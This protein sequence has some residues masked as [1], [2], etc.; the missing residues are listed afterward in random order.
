MGKVFFLFCTRQASTMGYW[1]FLRASRAS[2]FKF[3][4]EASNWASGH[5]FISP[6]LKRRENINNVPN[7]SWLGKNGD[8]Q[9]STPQFA[10]MG[11]MQNHII[12]LSRG[13]KLRHF[14]LIYNSR[15]MFWTSLKLSCCKTAQSVFIRSITYSS[16]YRSWESHSSCRSSFSPPIL[17][18][19]IANF[20]SFSYF[21]L[22]FH[23]RRCFLF[24]AERWALPSFIREYIFLI[25]K[26]LKVW[27]YFYLNKTHDFL[28]YSSRCFNGF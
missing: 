26:V 2:T 24:S 9:A 17:Y 3:H 22:R 25:Q 15:N 10:Y 11:R 19:Y 5:F 12:T 27:S 20:P 6:K 7:R 23:D 14:P 18:N 21:C 13:C 16:P 4:S 8:W 28:Q 1:K